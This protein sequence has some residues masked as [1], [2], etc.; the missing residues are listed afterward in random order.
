MSIKA[1]LLDHDGTIVDSEFSHYQMWAK[2]LYAFDVALTEADYK[3]NYAG[4]P[5]M[6]NAVN[7]IRHFN[8]KASEAEL[9]ESK[10]KETR[11][12]LANKPY[13]PIPDALETI[14]KFYNH[15]LKLAIVTGSNQHGLS[16]TA[17]SYGLERFV[18]AFISCDDVVNSKPAPECYLLAMAKLGVKPQDS[19]A[20]EDTE[21]GVKA[22][23]AAGIRCL[24]IPTEMSEHHDFST[25]EK[26]FEDIVEASDWII[27]RAV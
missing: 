11:A 27:D 12:F 5:A 15:G 22:A 16:R 2:V 20:I 25:A 3:N 8:M 18:S 21:H 19:V 1:V 9:V 24:A 14:E 6:S 10:L 26:V 7:M 23:V 4:M 17:E 13:P